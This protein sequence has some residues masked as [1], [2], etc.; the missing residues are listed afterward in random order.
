MGY[1]FFLNRLYSNMNSIFNIFGYN[2][3]EMLI[4]GKQKTELCNLNLV[5]FLRFPKDFDHISLIFL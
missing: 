2:N 1:P 3:V 5:I 4:F